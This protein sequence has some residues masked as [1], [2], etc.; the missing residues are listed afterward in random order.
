MVRGAFTPFALP[1]RS[2]RNHQEYEYVFLLQ[3]RP[4]TNTNYRY[5]GVRESRPEWLTGSP[6]KIRRG[7][8][9]HCYVS[10]RRHLAFTQPSYASSPQQRRESVS[11]GYEHVG[12]HEPESGCVLRS[13][14]VGRALLPEDAPR[15]PQPHKRACIV[16]DCDAERRTAWIFGGRVAL[17]QIIHIWTGSMCSLCEPLRSACEHFGGSRPC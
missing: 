10:P 11:A 15:R 13:F 3:Y 12:N 2:A 16:F 7:N 5:L 4:R 6:E 1:P 9:A 8:V 17:K 14:P